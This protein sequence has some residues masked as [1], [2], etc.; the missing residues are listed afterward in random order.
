MYYYFKK[1][2]IDLESYNNKNEIVTKFKYFT[3]YKSLYCVVGNCEN[4]QSEIDY[5]LAEYQRILETL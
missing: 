1:D 2:R 4:Y 5:I 3:E